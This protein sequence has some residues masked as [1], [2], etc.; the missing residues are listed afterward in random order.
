MLFRLFHLHFLFCSSR[1]K[2]RAVVVAQAKKKELVVKKKAVLDAK[3][4]KKKELALKSK[5]AKK[6]KDVAAKNTGRFE[7]D[8]CG[9]RFPT[10]RLLDIHYVEHAKRELNDLKSNSWIYEGDNSWIKVEEE[11][12][13]SEEES[14]AEDPSSSTNNNGQSKSKQMP[15][16]EEI[17]Q[18]DS[19]SICKICG[20]VLGTPEKVRQH[21]EAKHTDRFT[22]DHCP[23]RFKFKKDLQRHQTEMNHKTSMICEVCG[24]ACTDEKGFKSHMSRLHP[25]TEPQFPCSMC[26]KKMITQER[27]NSHM[28][29][30][31]NRVC[32]ICGKVFRQLK[33]LGRHMR[34]HNNSLPYTCKVC[35]KSFSSSSILDQH[36]LL[37]TGKKIYSC[38]VCGKTFA[39]KP[40][41][42]YH[43]RSH[44]RNLPPLPVVPIG[45]IVKDLKN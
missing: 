13:S 6:K 7:C 1:R 9:K 42:M 20:L 34:I 27:L 39:Q 12:K 41:L 36:L 2:R 31:H 28:E 3:E 32:S 35:N 14:E 25:T 21:W 44:S 5:T 15:T 19:Y 4:A 22:C 45:H 30:H 38:D 29:Q 16:D 11:S 8:N 40:G 37:H 10:R 18:P 43:R 24:K 33:N 17:D 23:A 26:C